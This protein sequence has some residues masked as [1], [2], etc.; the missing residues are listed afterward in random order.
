MMNFNYQFPGLHP[1]M[2][3]RGNFTSGEIQCPVSETL[4]QFKIGML[5]SVQK[6]D[7]Y[8]I[9]FVQCQGFLNLYK[10]FMYH[11]NCGVQV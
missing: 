9:W 2:Q 10:V 8:I 6:T 7:H 3:L 11:V 5:D 1:P 4:R